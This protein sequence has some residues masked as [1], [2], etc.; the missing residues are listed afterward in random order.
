MARPDAD[1]DPRVARHAVDDEVAVGRH[2]VDAGLAQE[3]WPHGA[4]QPLAEEGRDE[5]RLAAVGLGRARFLGDESPGHVPGRLDRHLAVHR[6]AIEQVL[7]VPDPH[8][9]AVRGEVAHVGR[10]EVAHLLLAERYPPVEAQVAEQGRQP[11]RH[12]QD[13]MVGLK[14][15]VIGGEG[16]PVR[17]RRDPPHRRVRPELRPAAAGQRDLRGVRPA[18]VEDP[19]VLLVEA[20]HIVADPPGGPPVPDLGGV[21][22]LGRNAEG[23][24]RAPVV[25]Q[26]GLPGRARR[27]PGQ[28]RRS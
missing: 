25:A 11:G 8:R 15:A 19:A 6:E 26:V 22:I 14:G 4:G 9:K 1:R 7:P 2:V 17:P 20:H 28:G 18:D 5:V 12:A 27:R 21:Q 13:D 23:R 24:Q 3:L 10:G 16:D